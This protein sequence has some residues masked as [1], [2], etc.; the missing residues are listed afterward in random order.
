MI[1][2]DIGGRKFS[3]AFCGTNAFY[4]RSHFSLARDK[5]Y[6]ERFD[7]KNIFKAIECCM[8]WGINTVETSAN[9]KI[10]QI[11]T[12]LKNKHQC[13]LHCV[14]STR[15]DETSTMKSHHQKLD[16][17]IN[18]KTTICVVH[19]QL[20]DN[21]R[22][23]N[24]MPWLP[25][26]LDKIHAAGLLAGISTHT[27][28]TVELCEKHGYP[29][30]TYLFPLNCTGFVNAEYKGTESVKER[31]DLVKGISKPFILIKTLGA[32]RIPPDEGLSFMAENTKPNDIISLGFG[33]E[34][35]IEETM[36]I[37]AKYFL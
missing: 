33:S 36:S 1:S 22:E 29:I 12:S 23:D 18:H 16:F 11:I 15:I 14:G 35:E 8:K 4:G 20:T 10:E 5:E 25:E 34:A 3:K 7:D 26:M 37:F 9:E 19:A 27:V 17:L 2:I 21:A 6:Q 32:G 13:V 31:V 28:N 24:A 30:D